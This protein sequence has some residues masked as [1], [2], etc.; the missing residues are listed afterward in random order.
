MKAYGT[1][2]VQFHS[3]T[4]TL[5]AGRAM[6]QALRHRPPIVEVRVHCQV[7]PCGICGAQVALAEWCLQKVKE[8]ELYRD[9][10]EL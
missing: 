1:V 6:A 10:H 8:N 7:T 9:V 2:E 3:L 5:G 4:R